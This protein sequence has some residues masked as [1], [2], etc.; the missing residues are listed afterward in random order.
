MGLN[1]YQAS[2]AWHPKKSWHASSSKDGQGHSNAGWVFQISRLQ[3]VR[4]GWRNST[5][6]KRTGWDRR[7]DVETK[8]GIRRDDQ[9]KRYW[10]KRE[11]QR[12]ARDNRKKNPR[13]SKNGRWITILSW[14]STRGQGWGWTQNF[15]T[16][17]RAWKAEKAKNGIQENA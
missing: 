1:G 11:G 9:V 15:W 4:K 12:R 2:V 14:R 13:V 5:F 7:G 16:R 17:S 8:R 10:D 3:A 6:R